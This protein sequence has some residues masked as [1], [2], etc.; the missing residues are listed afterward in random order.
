MPPR[1]SDDHHHHHHPK[2]DEPITTPGRSTSLA[3]R[4]AL[5]TALAAALAALVAALVSV[6]ISDRIVAAEEDRRLRSMAAVVIRE[7]PNVD[8]DEAATRAAVAE[9]V[10]ELA[11]ESIRIAV[12]R[13]AGGYGGNGGNGANGGNG[14]DALMIGGDAELPILTSGACTSRKEQSSMMRACAVEMNG[15]QVVAAAKRAPRETGAILA[16]CAIAA[17]LAALL[18]AL[19][20]RRTAR[21]ALA[22]LD[23]LRETL[24]RVADDDDPAKA[25][26][27]LSSSSRPPPANGNGKG[28][29]RSSSSSSSAPSSPGGKKYDSRNPPTLNVRE[30]ADVQVALQTLVDRLAVSLDTAR[31]FSADAAHEL[32][33]PLTVLSAEL[34]LLAEENLDESSRAAVQRLR[35]R[36]ASLAKLVERLL[37]LGAAA[38]GK[39]ASKEAVA[40]DEIA[41]DVVGE[42]DISARSRVTIH[43]EAVGTVLGDEVLLHAL[44]ENAV[45]NALKFSGEEGQVEVRISEPFLAGA[46]GSSPAQSSTSKVIV[47]IIDEGPGISPS[48][49]EHAFEP[50]FRTPESR[51]RASTPGHGI[52][53]ALVMQ[54]AR[55]HSGTAEFVNPAE[56]AGAHL[57]VTFPAWA[58]AADAQTHSISTKVRSGAPSTSSRST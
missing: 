3:S 35:R 53:L 22:P 18:A 51:A 30:V 20:A 5:G 1:P 13:A 21:W 10:G 38:S 6:V 29:A 36:V 17:G 27:I 44:I 56:G 54:I 31:R 32:K 8:G 50:F 23:H 28:S 46:H 41:R 14:G 52:G 47:E 57:R 4:V 34:D 15:Y 9:E 45:D 19:L 7:L 37:S 12:R 55:A 58:A 48:D 43:A 40:L 33:T 39:L 2:N 11:P 42:L 49:R 25:R 26:G 24:E 16:A